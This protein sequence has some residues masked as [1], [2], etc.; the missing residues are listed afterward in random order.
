[1]KWLKQQGCPWDSTAYLHAK[2]ETFYWLKEQGCPI[3]TVDF[4]TDMFMAF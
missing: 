3:I 4:L 1:M 2:T